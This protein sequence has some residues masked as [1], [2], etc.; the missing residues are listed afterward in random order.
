M[1]LGGDGW[2][3]DIGYGGVDHVLA[4]GENINIMVLDTEIYSNTGGQMS[5]ATPLG[6]SAKFAV[7]GKRTSK[8]SLA[9]QAVSYGNVYVAQ[10]AIGAK[11]LQTL[12]AIEEAEAYDGPSLIIAYSH[13]GDHGYDLRDGAI[14]ARKSCGNRLLAII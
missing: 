3:Y 1:D 6:A 4:S 5:K 13:C 9:L 7:S 11:D 12:K 2:A 10:I 14:A 8:K